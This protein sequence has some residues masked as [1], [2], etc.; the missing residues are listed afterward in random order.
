MLGWER[1]AALNASR[2]KRSANSSSSA[3]CSLSTLSA[4]SRSRVSSWAKVYLGHPSV[5]Q[6]ADDAVTVVY[7]GFLHEIVAS[8]RLIAKTIYVLYSGFGWRLFERLTTPSSKAKVE[9]DS[10]CSGKGSQVRPP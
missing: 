2:L 7:D 5:A 6:G 3:N 9:A 4:T 8:L 10:P 1:A